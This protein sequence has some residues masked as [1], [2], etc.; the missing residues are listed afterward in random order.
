MTQTDTRHGSGERATLTGFLDQQRTLVHGKCAGLADDGA[1]HAPLVTS[2]L[3]SIGGIVNH[4]R[5]VEYDWFERI[6]LGRPDLG[7][8]TDAEPDREFTLGAQTPIAEVLTA[9]EAQCTRNREIA[10]AHDLDTRAAVPSRHTGEHL[11]L[12]WIL[13]HMIEE[14]AR[15]LG[16]LDIL[17]EKWDGATGT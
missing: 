1:A 10:A 3:M 8:W 16:H 9:Y 11:T 5:W 2:P 13:A 7:P 4:L 17:R 14:T 15:H 12:R 6:L